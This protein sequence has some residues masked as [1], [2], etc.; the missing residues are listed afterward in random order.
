MT[1]TPVPR[2]L[3]CNTTW[4]CTQ[5]RGSLSEEM[6]HSRPRLWH[7]ETDTGDLNLALCKKGGHFTEV[8]AVRK[9]SR[10]VSE[11]CFLLFKAGKRLNKLLLLIR[12]RAKMNLRNSNSLD[13]AAENA[14]V[15]SPT[16]E[17]ASPTSPLF[18]LQ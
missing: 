15:V 11:W 12:P 3:P 18:V 16:R 2:G 7:R 1:G 13:S 4:E 9:T 6:E 8:T 17:S 5:A 14:C 10:F